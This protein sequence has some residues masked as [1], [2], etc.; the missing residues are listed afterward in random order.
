MSNRKKKGR[1]DSN[2]YSAETLLALT[3]Q[4]ASIS[5]PP[6]YLPSLPVFL[7]FNHHVF[8]HSAITYLLGNYY[9][10]GAGHKTDPHQN[11]CHPRR[12]SPWEACLFEKPLCFL[13]QQSTVAGYFM[14]GTGKNCAKSLFLCISVWLYTHTHLYITFAA[15]LSWEPGFGLRA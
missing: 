5:L 12:A 3:F 15:A 1:W 13:F 11:R 8:I 4:A 6:S 10:P 9:I 2:E 7:P 14:F